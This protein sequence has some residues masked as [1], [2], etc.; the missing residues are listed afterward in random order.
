M[1]DPLRRTLLAKLRGKKAKKGSVPADWSNEEG[2]EKVLRAQDAHSQRAAA[3]IAELDYVPNA[4]RGKQGCVY[5][6][7]ERTTNESR[8]GGD[9][10]GG[11]GGQD[12]HKLSGVSGNK[13]E[14]LFTNDVGK[15]PVAVSRRHTEGDSIGFGNCSEVPFI[16]VMETVKNAHCREPAFKPNMTKEKHVEVERCLNIGRPE[17]GGTQMDRS[18][19]PNL[20]QFL[21]SGHVN[22]YDLI[23]TIESSLELCED[24]SM[25]PLQ[26][27]TIFP[28][29]LEIVD[30]DL[31]PHLVCAREGMN[32]TDSE[33]DDYY[34]NEILPFY[35]SGSRSKESNDSE[36]PPRTSLHPLQSESD[37]IVD[38][39][40]QE[41]DRLRSQLKEAYY[42]LINAMDGIAFDGQVQRNGY[43][44]QSSISSLSPDSL[45]IS[46]DSSTRLSRS[47]GEH[48]G[49]H[50]S[51]PS[52]GESSAANCR[53]SQRSK[54]LQNL[55][56]AQE[57]PILQR[58]M[59]DDGIRYPVK[60]REREL[61]TENGSLAKNVPDDTPLLAN[62][63]L[64]TAATEPMVSEHAD[65][66]NSTSVNHQDTSDGVHHRT[67]DPVCSQQ[68]NLSRHV[69]ASAGKPPGVTVNKM[70]EWMHKGRLL[71]SEMRQR[72][73]GSSSHGVA[74]EH[75]GH[76][77]QAWTKTFKQ[78]NSVNGEK[79]GLVNPSSGHH[80][81]LL[82]VIDTRD[83][84]TRPVPLNSITV[85]KK[86]NWLNQ[87]STRPSPIF[88]ENDHTHPP[89]VRTHPQP[90]T[91]IRLHTHT[92]QVPASDP[93]EENDADDEGEIWYNPI[94]EDEEVEL[95]HSEHGPR[96]PSRASGE[97]V[98]RTS[99]TSRDSG[100]LNASHSSEQKHVY[101]QMCR[102]Q[103][104]KPVI[105]HTATESPE[106]SVPGFSPP[107]SPNPAKKSC[108]INW[109][110]PERIKSPR[111][112]RKLSIKMRKI[113]E[114]SRKLSVKGN[115]TNGQ[116]ESRNH[117]LRATG[118]ADLGSGGVSTAS[119]SGNVIWRYHL[120]SSVCTQQQKKSSGLGAP[121]SAI[122]G[123]Y[124]SDGD[125]PELVVK[126]AKHGSCSKSHAKTQEKDSFS[127][128]AISR[129]ADAASFHPYSLPEQAKCT[130][131]PPVS[132]L[133]SMHLCGAEG[134]KAPR[135]DE[136]R[137]VYC[138]I[139]VDEAKRARTALLPCRTD[140]LAMDHTFQ[141]E[142]EEA[143][144]LRLVLFS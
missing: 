106:Q 134:L 104:E 93:A 65:Q 73:A 107:S 24:F 51:L 130:S 59:S 117:L 139:Q 135:S 20:F 138:A 12:A 40:A 22:E 83:S 119:T 56:L 114:L 137:H 88:D 82:P 3:A 72:I 103:E 110:F 101:R 39:S 50:W 102:F 141:L 68:M 6:G 61:C 18:D 86:R 67:S 132:G 75:H 44:E 85:S 16:P 136:S 80:P 90:Q 140:F 41:T 11:Y 33:D 89:Q 26:S 122:K 4:M 115:P 55:L 8:R 27:P 143:Q 54:S 66:E 128:S 79:T 96:V 121:K 28:T 64:E 77:G 105:R 112:V 35:K 34:D 32:S 94:P 74:Q 5:G 127:N 109:S 120:D 13:H 49:H 78:V 63:D 100:N 17:P 87:S 38:S 116:T 131:S 118:T 58:S 10:S 99:S 25:P 2:K 144:R 36:G 19:P 23:R 37:Q 21:H 142:L 30:V 133:L 7:S 70:Q 129:L 46:S 111:T 126:S 69:G 125:S 84:C 108:S 124:L 60:E 97:E 9:Q 52:P 71:S 43:V 123:G 42:L 47:S 29:E 113:P 92:L 14:L 57:R 53:S 15:Q 91:C 62:L 31:A 45:S 98:G 81:G 95:H 1:A 76:E 48:G